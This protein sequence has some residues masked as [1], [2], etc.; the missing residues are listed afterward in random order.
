MNIGDHAKSIEVLRRALDIRE[1]ALGT[2]HPAVAD[3]LVNLIAAM[4]VGAEKMPLAQG[5][6]Q[7]E[8]AEGKSYWYNPGKLT[9][10]YCRPLPDAF[11]DGSGGPTLK[12]LETRLCSLESQSSMS[13]NLSSCDVL[14]GLQVCPLTADAV[15][16]CIVKFNQSFFFFRSIPP[17]GTV[18]SK[19]A[20]RGCF[21]T[22]FVSILFCGL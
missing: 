1:E 4:R 15:I 10:Q 2:G 13:A 6:E 14:F 16:L 8:D 12:D 22:V 18:C 19:C 3:I 11:C 20:A 17:S 21:W 5:W 7:K 9:V